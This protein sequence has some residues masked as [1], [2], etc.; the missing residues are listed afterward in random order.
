MIEARELTKRY[1]DKTVVDNLSFTVKPGE[2][3][4]F[5]GPNGAG[6][7]T[8]MRMIVGL[9]SPTKG[10]VTVGGRSYAKHVAPLQEIG[11]LLE[12]KS[13]HPGRSAFNHLMALARTHGIPR[14]R[15]NEVIELAG[16]T[17]VADKRV[18]AF[19]LGMGQRLGIA[20]ALLGDPA[21]IMLDEP[22]NGLDPEGVLWVRTLLRRLADEGRAVMLSSHLMSETALIADHLVIIG[23]G[24][25]LA[26]TTVDDFTR[27]AGG[28]G[29]KVA[30]VE[31]TRLRSLLAGPDVVITSSAG[32]E[33][34]V[35]GRDAREIGA[36]AAQHGVPLY[37][38]TPQAVS[39]EAA[40]MELTRDVVEYQSAPADT[41]AH[42]EAHTERKAA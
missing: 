19:S 32:E 34:Q 6:K 11:T 27:E 30:S 4:G 41:E 28:G 14:R 2:V 5:L 20:S 37:E 24:R 9:D 38:L 33:L 40:F 36:I 23:R 42:T 10:S 22:V 3:T 35:T 1:G 25:L 31:A 29:V 26:D 16:L 8:T 7:S 12:A 21:I 17:S 39:L 13:V 18:G 15:V